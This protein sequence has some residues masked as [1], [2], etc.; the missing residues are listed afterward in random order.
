MKVSINYNLKQNLKLNVWYAQNISEKQIKLSM[1]KV[2][3]FR[4]NLQT[5]IFLLFQ[6][7]E[8]EF[9]I[10]LLNLVWSSNNQREL[11]FKN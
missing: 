8:I 4:S 2:L 9:F 11:I 5:K 1:I 6:I 7:K 10:K 3:K